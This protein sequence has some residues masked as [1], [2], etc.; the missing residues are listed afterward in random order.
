MDIWVDVFDSNGQRLGEGPVFNIIQAQV[1]R[2]LDG[3]GGFSFT[4]PAGEDRGLELLEKYRRVKIWARSP[5]HT[6]RLLGQGVI[7]KRNFNETSGNA[8][9]TIA[10]PDILHE[11]KNKNV[12]FAR[13]YKQQ[14]LSSVLN[15][16]ISL[17]PGWSITVLASAPSSLIE[18]RFDGA[19]VLKALQ[20]VVQQVGTH[21]RLSGDREIEVGAFGDDDGRRV[22]RVERIDQSTLN[23]NLLLIAQSTSEVEDSENIFNVVVPIGAGEGIAALTLEHSTRTSPYPIQTQTM[24]DGSTMYYLSNSSSVAT[25]GSIE[26]PRKYDNI[27]PISNTDADIENAANALYDAAVIDLQRNSESQ[28]VYSIPLKNIKENLNPGDKIHVRYKGRIISTK[29]VAVDFVD[30]SGD[31]WMMKV[32]ETVSA[33]GISAMAD[34]SDVDQAQ[35]DATEVIVG[36]IES[37]KLRGLKPAQASSVRSY[38]YTR[39]IDSNHSATVPI[40]ISDATLYVNRVRVRLKTSAF[41][42]TA[43]AAAGGGDHRHMMF[44]YVGTAGGTPGSYANFYGALPNLGDYPFMLPFPVGAGTD[45]VYTRESSGEHSHDLDYGISDDSQKPKSISI[46]INGINRTLALGGPFAPSGQAIDIVLDEGLVTDYILDAPGGVRQV[47]DLEI[48]C[49]SQQG[50]IEVTVEIFEVN[51]AIKLT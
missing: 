7:T 41:R 48:R 27:A 17:V 37:V 40:E 21:F 29:G 24:P 31:F 10:G 47:H 23:N 3:A 28:T 34:I 39:D 13:S 5:N 9:R 15:D 32:K 22:F 18:A 2:V 1:T 11:L 36:A 14:S 12:W 46:Y 20:S 25:Y 26:R 16:L 51:Q 30:I 4:L 43:Q 45:D 8:T 38:V 33:S 42:A 44:E 49:G 50:R 6:K 19:S 35:V